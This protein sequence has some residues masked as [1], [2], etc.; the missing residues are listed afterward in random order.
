MLC[1]G[2][3]VLGVVVPTFHA[4]LWVAC[5]FLG[6][7]AGFFVPSYFELISTRVEIQ[8]QNQGK[9]QAVN[10]WMAIVGI[11]AGA[12][13]FSSM[14]NA[15]ARGLEAGVPFDLAAAVVL[16][17]FAVLRYTLSLFPEVGL[18][19]SSPVKGPTGAAGNGNASSS[20]CGDRGESG[21]VGPTHST[22]TA[23][24]FLLSTHYIL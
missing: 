8:I 10:S 5:V 11:G 14:L 9:L 24:R 6:M 23:V 1:A 3:L 22:A 12:G 7:G 15:H 20:G 19:L 16:A 18:G 21:G 2:Y 13:V 17:A 4:W